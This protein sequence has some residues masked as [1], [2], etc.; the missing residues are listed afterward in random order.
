M[1]F[2]IAYD[3]F[4]VFRFFLYNDFAFNRVYSNKLFIFYCLFNML[5]HI[6]NLYLLK[7]VTK[8]IMPINIDRW[9]ITTGFL[10]G[11]VYSVIPNNKD[12]CDC[13]MKFL[14]FVFFFCSAFV[15]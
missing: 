12:S 9:R 15:F 13:N 4:L 7:S 5:F 3:L 11:K 2:F 1:D 6:Y 8:S 14:I 10:Y